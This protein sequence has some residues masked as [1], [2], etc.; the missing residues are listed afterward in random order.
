[1]LSRLQSGF[2]PARRR[3]ESCPQ[4]DVPIKE[5]PDWLEFV[6]DYFERVVD[7]GE[8]LGATRKSTRKPNRRPKGQHVQHRQHGPGHPEDEA[9]DVAGFFVTLTHWHLP[10]LINATGSFFTK[11]E[12]SGL[13]ALI[14]GIEHHDRSMASQMPQLIQGD[15]AISRAGWV[16]VERVDMNAAVHHATSAFTWPSRLTRMGLPS[17]SLPKGGFIE[18]PPG[19]TIR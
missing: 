1:M 15:W 13:T 3:G 11:P 5:L 8:N 14:A 18:T 7:D 10:N 2:F 12:F 17:D 19:S 16:R 9:A 4:S 6:V